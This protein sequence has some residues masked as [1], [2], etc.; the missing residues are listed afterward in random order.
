MHLIKNG[1]ATN[2]ATFRCSSLKESQFDSLKKMFS[3][4]EVR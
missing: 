3:F 2:R 1:T 4:S